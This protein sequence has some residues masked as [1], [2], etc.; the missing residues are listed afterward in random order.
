MRALL[1][2]LSD[3]KNKE[4]EVFLLFHCFLKLY[5]LYKFIK[6][7]CNPTYSLDFLFLVSVPNTNKSF[8]TKLEQE[9]ERKKLTFPIYILNNH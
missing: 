5:L 1:L 4:E 7:A 2:F 6:R 8:L 3:L 9:E